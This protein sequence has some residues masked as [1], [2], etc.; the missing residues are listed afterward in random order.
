[1]PHL[2]KHIFICT[3]QREPGNPK[4]CCADK[5]AEAISGIF[6]ERGSCT[7]PQGK[8]ARQPGGLSRSMR[9]RPAV[10]VYPEQIW[11]TV[12]TIEDAREIF[13]KHI[14]GGTPVE[15]LRMKMTRTVEFPES[16]NMAHYFLDARI[17]QGAAGRLPSSTI[18]E[19]T[20]SSKCKSA[21]TKW[22][23]LCTHVASARRSRPYRPVRQCGICRGVFRR[24]QARRGGDDGQSGIAR[25]RLRLLLGLHRARA[26]L[27]DATLAD[28]IATTVKQNSLLRT[29][30]AVGAATVAKTWSAA[31]DSAPSSFSNFPHVER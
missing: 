8:S 15:R 16:F 5:G 30:L 11:Y 17:E 6:Q 21:P 14:I 24:A 23:M 29:V 19:A 1:M 28:R 3:N 10:V 4:G 22:P 9:A 13:E 27:A 12:P 18:A 26:F 7:R 25:R 31:V 2:E 20:P